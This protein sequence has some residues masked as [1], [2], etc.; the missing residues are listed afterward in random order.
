[1]KTATE[2]LIGH[3]HDRINQGRTAG[4]PASPEVMRFVLAWVEAVSN[5]IHEARC[6][7]DMVCSRCF[8][9]SPLDPSSECKSCRQSGV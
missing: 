2:L 8:T 1:M 7:G 4:L 3:C 5:R 6:R 9:L